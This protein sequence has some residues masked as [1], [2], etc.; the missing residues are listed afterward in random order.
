M[1]VNQLVKNFNLLTIGIRNNEEKNGDANCIVKV[2]RG[3]HW[4]SD[5]EQGSS[6]NRVGLQMDTKSD[7][8]GF[9]IVR[10]LR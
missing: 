1:E 4:D 7:N 3:G 5:F 2:H 9:R 6:A 8:I 10:T